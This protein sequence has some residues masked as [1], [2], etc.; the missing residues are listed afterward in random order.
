MH[1]FFRRSDETISHHFY[2]VIVA[3]IELEEIFLKQSNGIEVPK[4]ILNNN[5]F[6][7][8]FKVN[9]ILLNS[10]LS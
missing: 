8:Y 5:R 10:K 4:E 1:F 9:T 2:S 3:I 6:Y 7:P